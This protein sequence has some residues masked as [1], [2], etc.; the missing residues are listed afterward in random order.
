MEYRQPVYQ[1]LAEGCKRKK[2]TSPGGLFTFLLV[3][4]TGI[5]PVLPP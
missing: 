4:D 5:E 2:P 3:T 1:V